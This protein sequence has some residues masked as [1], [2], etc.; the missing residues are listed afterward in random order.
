[1]PLRYSDCS[2]W[3]LVSTFGLYYI[4]LH[5]SEDD[6][7]RVALGWPD[8]FEIEEKKREGWYVAK[9]KATWNKP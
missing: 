1:M 6:V 5:S 9:A 3:V 7:W 4:G 2:V 8:E